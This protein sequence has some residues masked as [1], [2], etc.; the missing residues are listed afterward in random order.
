MWTKA[1]RGC[2]CRMER[3]D[4]VSRALNFLQSRGGVQTTTKSLEMPRQPQ[5]R[6]ASDGTAPRDLDDS[7]VGTYEQQFEGDDLD[8]KQLQEAAGQKKGIL[9]RLLN[10]FK[11]KLN[12]GGA[13][14]GPRHPTSPKQ[15]PRSP[16]RRSP[17]AV[18]SATA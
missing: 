1:S 3:P 6:A 18:K 4:R 5:A 7:E 15:T 11:R 16:T 2:R 8:P 10:K 9:R 12:S 14:G 13:S 17:S